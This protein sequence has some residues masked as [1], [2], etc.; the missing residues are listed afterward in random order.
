LP[1]IS[2]VV[3]PRI[4]SNPASALRRVCAAAQRIP[5]GLWLMWLAA[6]ASVAAMALFLAPPCDAKDY[7]LALSQ[8]TA[9]P[10]GQAGTPLAYSPLFMIPTLWMARLLPLWL[11][12]GLYGVAYFSGWLTQ[13]WVG[14]QFATPEERAILRYAAPLLTFFPGL[15]ISDVITAGNVAYVLYGL[16]LA[17]A[18]WGWSRGRWSWFYLA[19][20]ASACVK[21]QLLTMLAIPLLCGRRQWMRAVAAGSVGV[22]LYA[23]QG[24]L[25]PQSFHVYLNTLQVMSHSRRDFGCSLVGNVARVLW[26]AGMPYEKLCIVLYAFYALALFALLCGLARLYRAQ[27]IC[28]ESWAPVMLIGVIL[29][30]PRIQS[31]DI[32]A[33]TLPM[34][35]VA[36]RALCGDD[37]RIRRAEAIGSAILLLGITVLLQL[38]ESLRLV[39]PDAWK[40]AEMPMLLGIF[41]VGVRGL[42]HEAGV[43]SVWQWDAAE[44]EPA[45]F[46]P[47]G[48]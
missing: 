41:A 31:Y 6:A 34:A 4:E 18:A 19:V 45:A 20:L 15:L 24:W 1:T 25:F 16:M 8:Y 2:R 10:G 46:E 26:V 9:H 27:R 3:A 48:D 40:Y 42:L 11:T 5:L 12:V 23:M 35:L 36:W 47:V 14:M 38:N 13:L 28:L 30:S 7:L 43:A 29:L 39:L 37:G 17:A 33:V 44:A 22:S 21:V 32:A